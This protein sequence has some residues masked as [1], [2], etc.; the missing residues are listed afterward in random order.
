M[1][2]EAAIIPKNENS[3]SKTILT[4]ILLQFSLTERKR[5]GHNFFNPFLHTRGFWYAFAGLVLAQALDPVTAQAVLAAI[6]GA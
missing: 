4:N 2:Q 5:P 1:M 3:G 6:T